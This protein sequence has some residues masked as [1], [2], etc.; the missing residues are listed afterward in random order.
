MSAQLSLYANTYWDTTA[1]PSDQ[2]AAAIRAAEDQDAA[3][4]AILQ[5]G[6]LLSPSQVWDAGCRVGRSW[7]LTS[8]RRSMSNLTDAKVLV[9]TDVKRRGPYG[10]DE[11]CWMRAA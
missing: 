5:P 9:R 6:R 4:L 7:L 1:L 11:F 2:L 8:V 3:V 10:R